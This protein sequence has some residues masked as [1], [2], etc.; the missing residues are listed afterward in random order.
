MLGDELPD[1][2]DVPRNIR[3]EGA[4]TTMR[5]GAALRRK[6]RSGSRG[7]GRNSEGVRYGE[8]DAYERQWS[9]RRGGSGGRV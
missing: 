2:A 7:R 6:G 4:G 1:K 5:R 8:K 9:R 3:V